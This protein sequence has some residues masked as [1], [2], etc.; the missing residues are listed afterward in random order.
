MQKRVY[1]SRKEKMIAGVAGGLGEYFEIDPVIIRIIFVIAALAGGWGVLAYVLCWIIIPQAPAGE[2]T[3]PKGRRAPAS[4]ET[5]PVSSEEIRARRSLVPGILLI[6]LGAL[7]LA[8][9]LIPR[10]NF[11]H[12]WPLILIAIGVGLLWKVFPRATT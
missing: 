3:P 7:L 10:F 9:N 8:D 4:G 12:F 5:S 11:G 1:R 2:E 6:I